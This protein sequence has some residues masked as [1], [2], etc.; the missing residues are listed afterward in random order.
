MIIF[1]LTYYSQNSAVSSPSMASLEGV[2]SPCP[3]TLNLVEHLRPGAARKIWTGAARPSESGRPGLPVRPLFP[4]VLTLRAGHRHGLWTGGQAHGCGLALVKP[5]Q[6]C[7]SLLLRRVI[8]CQV[9]NRRL[10]CRCGLGPVNL[11][12]E[13]CSLL[14]RRVIGNQDWTRRLARRCGLGLVK[15]HQDSSSLFLRQRGIG[16]QG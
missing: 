9:L 13:C 4:H 14:L 16:Q 10:A 2:G 12:Q 15:P 5:G 1:S 7:C 6:E 3:T 11:H 8:G